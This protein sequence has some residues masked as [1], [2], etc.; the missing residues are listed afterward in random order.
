MDTAALT[1]MHDMTLNRIHKDADRLAD[2]EARDFEEQFTFA[3]DDTD[4]V[5]LCRR[6]LKLY[7]PQTGRAA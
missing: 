6:W 1:D 7:A 2:L 3:E 5:R 4:R